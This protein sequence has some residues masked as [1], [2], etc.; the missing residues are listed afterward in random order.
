MTWSEFTDILHSA[1]PRKAGGDDH[2]NTYLLSVLPPHL[3]TLFFLV[4]NRFLHEPLPPHWTTAE[5]CLIYKKKC[6]H[7]PANYRPIALL[8]TVYKLVARHAASA[9]QTFIRDHSLMHHSQHGGM[10]N[11]RTMD[12]LF[13][14]TAEIARSPQAYHFYIDFNKAF[15]SVP[16]PTLRRVLH[17]YRMPAGLVD[18]ISGLYAHPQDAP[19][20]NN[21]TPYHYLQTRGLRQGCPMSPVLFI[22][23]SNVLLHAAPQ[24]SLLEGPAKTSAHAFIDDKLYRSPS[25]TYIQKLIDFYD[26]DARTWGLQMNCDKS[27]VHAL[28]GVPQ[29]DFQSPSGFTLSTVDP[30]TKQPRKGYKYLGVYIY[31]DKHPPQLRHQIHSELNSYFVHLSPLRLTLPELVKL[32]NVQLIPILTYRLIAHPFLP[33]AI[34]ELTAA[35]WKGLATHGRISPKVSTKDIYQPRAKLGLGLRHLGIAVHKSFV[36]AGLRY[37]NQDGPPASC[38]AV[39]DTLLLTRQNAL[40]DSFLDA[41]NRLSLRFHAPGP[42]NPCLPCELHERE[43]LYAAPRN[44]PPCLATVTKVYKKTATIC[45]DTGESATITERSNFTFTPPNTPPL[46]PGDITHYHLFPPFSSPQTRNPDIPVPLQADLMDSTCE[47][48]WFHLPN[49][50][51]VLNHEDLMGWG[52]IQAANLVAELPFDDTAWIYTDGSSGDGGHG[53]AFAI[54]WQQQCYILCRSS[55]SPTSGGSEQWAMAM[56]LAH[57]PN[58]LPNTPVPILGDNL[59]TVEAVNRAL[60]SPPPP[61]RPSTYTQGTRDAAYTSLLAPLPHLIHVPW[62]KGHAHFMGN[63]LA[64]YFSK[65]AAQ[66]L[67]WHPSLLPPPPA[68]VVTSG[69]LALMSEIPKHHTRSLFPTHPDTRLHFGTSASFLRQSSFFSAIA[70]K[71]VSGTYGCQDYRPHCDTSDRTCPKCQ[72]VHPMDPI[73]FCALCPTM[74]WFQQCLSSAWPPPFDKLALEWWIASDRGNR[75]LAASHDILHISPPHVPADALQDLEAPSTR[76]STDPMA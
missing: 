55:P 32:V 45:L 56:A 37:L 33:S 73:S 52:C 69:G 7:D 74:Q 29:H 24:P 4:V 23:Y 57:L 68:G 1:N 20:V 61:A 72:E 64:D 58:I 46:P 3:Q 48:H 40:Q 25:Q 36:E 62:I 5:V 34:D 47:G 10:P 15:N 21:V 12:H 19:L 11:F 53:S 41:A 51:H 60:S 65:W 35:V 16:Q 14:V 18:L 8:N 30:D 17:H 63:E 26:T 9:L 75:R 6:P 66:A 49:L 2:T 38:V 54:F 70:F 42:W 13:H 50:R 71:W 31:N 67:L 59:D 22:L 44:A 43:R 39:R 27:E 28:G 76:I